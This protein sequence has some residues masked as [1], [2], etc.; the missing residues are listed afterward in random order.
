MVKEQLSEEQI[1]FA[2]SAEAEASTAVTEIVRTLWCQRA[3]LFP[4]EE[5]VRRPRH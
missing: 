4:V 3:D 2:L 1:A 5:A